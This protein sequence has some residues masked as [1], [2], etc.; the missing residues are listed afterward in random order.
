MVVEWK[1]RFPAT[2]SPA[3]RISG[4]TGSI[5]GRCDRGPRMLTALKAFHASNISKVPYS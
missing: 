4:V 2:R 1:E 3:V 5:P